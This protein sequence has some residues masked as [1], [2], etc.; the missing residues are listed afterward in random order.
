MEKEDAGRNPK[1]GRRK[2]NKRVHC[3]VGFEVFTA[4]FG[5]TATTATSCPHDVTQITFI[6]G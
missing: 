2:M 1:W 4:F 3:Y 5:Y 6:S